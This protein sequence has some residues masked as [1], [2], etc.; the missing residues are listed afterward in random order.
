MSSST[1]PIILYDFDVDDDFSTTNIPNYT[2][3]SPNYSP[4]S[5][6][7]TFSDPSENLTQNLLS[8]L[9]ISPFYDDLYMKVM[10]AYNAELP[11]QA[12]IAPP[13][14]LMLSPQFDSRDFFLPKEI[15]HLENE[16]VSYH[17][18]LLNLL[19]HLTYL[20]PKKI[21]GLQKKQ[22]GHDDEVVL[23]RVRISTLEM[24]I[25]DIQAAIRKLVTD[26]VAT[27]L[28][29]Q[30][31]NMANDENTNRKTKPR[32][33]LVA[34]KCSYKKFM[35]C[36]PFNFKGTE[37]AVGLIHWFEQTELVFSHSRCTKDWKVKFATGTLIEEGL[38]WWNSF[39]Q[40]IGIEEAYKELAV[41]CPTMVQNSEKLMKVFIEGLPRSIE[42]YVTTSKPQTLDEAITITQRL[43]DQNRR[44]ETIKACAA[45]LTENRRY[46]RN[47]PYVED[48]S[49]TTQDL[50]Q[51]S[52]ILVTRWA[53]D[54]EL[55]KQ[56]ASHEKQSTTSVSDLSCMRRERALQKSVPKSKQ[57]CPRKSIH[58]EGH[59]RSSSLERS[60]GYVPSKSTSS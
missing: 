46:V 60:H 40:P 50:A 28:E 41:L 55:Q 57:Q 16:P 42:G 13:L 51:S 9:A 44:Q 8:V 2:P 20:R 58:V 49:Y 4:A 27:A 39:A 36:Q 56:R 34:R 33:A 54:Q 22:M 59:K 25:E 17:T 53:T 32:E 38:S 43:M 6:G 7:N 19:P 24:I 14:S 26:S 37:C 21:A 23:A 3:A 12:P 48:V 31:A 35:S 5:P 1:H 10:Q 11:I 45:T 47:F 15:W 18:P 52:V 29:A 30:A